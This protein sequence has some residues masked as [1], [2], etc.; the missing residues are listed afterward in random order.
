M[1]I[2]NTIGFI[3]SRNIHQ[4]DILQTSVYTFYK[5]SNRAHFCAQKALCKPLGSGKA[6]LHENHTMHK[7][8]SSA[9]SQDKDAQLL[10][11]AA[12][13]LH[14]RSQYGYLSRKW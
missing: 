12:N 13:S 9:N 14:L 1:A 8:I 2:E 10:L 5:W 6:S 4:N 11:A 3:V 7:I